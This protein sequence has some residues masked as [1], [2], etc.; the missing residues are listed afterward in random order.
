MFQNNINITVRMN[1]KRPCKSYRD[2]RDHQF[3]IKIDHFCN[4]LIVIVK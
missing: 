2:V 4:I 3:D 1:T